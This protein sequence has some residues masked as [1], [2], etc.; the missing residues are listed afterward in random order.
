M[1]KP[2]K[3]VFA[4]VVASVAGLFAADSIIQQQAP[5]DGQF[6][7]A[8]QLT[9]EEEA[10]IVELDALMLEFSDLELDIEQ[11][12]KTPVNYSRLFSE[13]KVRWLLTDERLESGL[14]R[15]SEPTSRSGSPFSSPRF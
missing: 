14:R 12:N 2:L 5:L 4:L 9:P 3:P 15:M 6:D 10:Q 13:G 7:G 8:Y 11:T 1:R